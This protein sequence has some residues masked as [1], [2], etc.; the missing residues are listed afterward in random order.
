MTNLV[1]NYRTYTSSISEG[2]I[3]GGNISLSYQDQYLNENSP[4]NLLN[5][6]TAPTLSISFRQNLGQGFG[7]K[8][9]SRNIT[10]AKAN[11]KINDLNFKTEVIATV[12]NVL[13]LYYGL[14]ADYE[15]VRAK[16]EA[17]DVAQRFYEDN[18]KQV[19]IGTMAPLDVTT[20][21]AQLASSQQD[22]AV[23]QAT[24]A[25]QQVSLKSVLSRT[26]LG[27][28]LL[29]EVDDCSARPDRCAGKR[30]SPS[31]KR[32]DL[33]LLMQTAWTFRLRRSTCSTMRRMR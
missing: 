28:P 11:V 30:R 21:E 2:L 19:Q 23:S 15:D 25:Q 33:R 14:V 17:V 12:V 9:N 3:T 6:S 32:S 16:S 31:D 29:R 4:V 7:I 26:G 13:D 24:L 27:E 18:K 20:A 5:P 1:S 22:L 10:V 8:L